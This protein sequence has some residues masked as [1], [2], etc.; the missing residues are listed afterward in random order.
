MGSTGGEWGKGEK[1]GDGREC[2]A[3]RKRGGEERD[4]LG[5]EGVDEREKLRGRECVRKR[6][7]VGEG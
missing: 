4:R 5:R 1:L 7:C 6:D 2:R 3:Q